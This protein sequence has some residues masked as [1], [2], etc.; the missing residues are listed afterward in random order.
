MM[1]TGQML[2]IL[3]ALVLFSLLL[4]SINQTI[5]YND[6]TL[7]ASNA[8][9]AAMSIAQRLLAEAG[10]KE[11]DVACI[12]GPVLMPNQLTSASHLG[13]ASGETY[14]N[15]NDL[16]DFDGLSIVD[17]LTFPSVPFTV[18]AQVDYVNPNNPT[19]VVGSPTFLKRLQVMVSGAY[20]INPM[21]EQPVQVN[22]EQIF[23]Y[24]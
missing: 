17:S 18:T 3:G 21:S 7:I 6:R 9:M 20:L 19:V 16:D 1:N 12:T 5:L 15:F 11:F 8:E 4:P 13:P 10:T 14:P 2:L 23:A 24:F 22:M